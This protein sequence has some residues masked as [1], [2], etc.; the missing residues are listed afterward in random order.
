MQIPNSISFST[1]LPKFSSPFSSPKNIKKLSLMMP[2]PGTQEF[3]TIVNSDEE[4][5]ELEDFLTIEQ[6]IHKGGDIARRTKC[7]LEYFGDQASSSNIDNDDYFEI[8]EM[9]A[10]SKKRPNYS[11]GRGGGGRRGRRRH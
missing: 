3:K 2:P 6:M 4:L 7:I 1:D 5:S 11:Q 9:K 10:S 8:E